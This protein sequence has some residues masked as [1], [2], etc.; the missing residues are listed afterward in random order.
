[1]FE[2]GV[3]GGVQLLLETTA[4]QGTCIGGALEELAQ[5]LDLLRYPERVAVCADTCHLFAA[6]YDIS[7][8]EGYATTFDRLIELVGLDR[9]KAFHLNDSK[10]ACG[11]HLDRHE[12]IGDGQIGLEGF[13]QLIN[14]PRFAALP[15]VL[16]TP[17]GKDAADDIR[18]LATLRGLRAPEDILAGSNVL[19]TEE[20][21]ANV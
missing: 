9:V 2:A 12:G 15:M 4:G 13:R 18:N 6:G 11:S 19:V 8:P 21:T 17:K 16:E 1:M 10:G 5:I 20:S 14:D 3:G 7:T